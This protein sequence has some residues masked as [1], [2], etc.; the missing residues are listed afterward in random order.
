MFNAGNKE[1]VAI[2]ADEVA[3]RILEEF[4]HVPTSAAIDID[5]RL[6][7]REVVAEALKRC[8]DLLEKLVGTTVIEDDYLTDLEQQ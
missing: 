3:S 6:L 1:H 2:F 7:V 8:P 5:D 4:T